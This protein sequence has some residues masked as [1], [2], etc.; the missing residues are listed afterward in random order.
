MLGHPAGRDVIGGG[1]VQDGATEA[2]AA[3]ERR[4]RGR[5]GRGFE[6]QRGL[7]QA[8]AP[9]AGVR[10]A[11]DLGGVVHQLAAGVQFGG[12]VDAHGRAEGLVAELVLA[13]P[14]RPDRPAGAAH[15]DDRRID[16]RVVR[17]VVAI[18][19]GALGVD[20]LDL[21]RGQAAD[22]G[23]HGAQ[24]I[25]ALSVGPDSERAVLHH[26]EP[27]GRAHG[28]VRDIG[29][30]VGGLQ[31]AA[32]GFAWRGLAGG[33]GGVRKI[34]LERLRFGE[35]WREIAR[36][37]PFGGLLCDVQRDCD[38]AFALGQEGDE[39][40]FPKDVDVL[41]RRPADRGLVDRLQPRLEPR[42]TQDTGVQHARLDQVVQEG[43]AEHLGRQVEPAWRGPDQPVAIGRLGRDLASRA[44]GQIH[45]AGQR[46][47]GQAGGR[48][49]VHEGAILDIEF[50]GVA[51]QA[52]SGG[53][54][55]QRPGLGASRADRG[56]GGFGAHRADGQALVW[57]KVGLQIDHVQP[58]Q[59][60]VQ[61][62]GG[63]L[64]Q[65]GHGAL[66]IFDLAEGDADDARRLEPHPAVKAWIGG[67]ARRD[68]RPT[69]A[70]MRSAARATA[71]MIRLCAPQRQRCQD[72]A[73][74][75]SARLGS[76]LASI[77]AL[78]PTSMPARQ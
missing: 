56:A 20:H 57:R 47:I 38:G 78:A 40:S 2:H 51:A 75:I 42:L 15:G 76:G 68:H 71:A 58:V 1:G 70:R 24:G 60:D 8:A 61:L 55:E 69:S 13:P 62:L 73:S 63:D 44:L 22:A 30:S 25:D 53:L 43:R 29:P 72:S 67:E 18:G 64:R 17:A 50:A 33:I 34:A 6:A 23:Q 3:G 5:R 31:P 4:W 11:P 26:R 10:A 28:A 74:A 39:V 59:A 41:A 77:S 21:V 35:A 14:L 49:A 16:R 54:G 46:P 36:A 7:G 9:A 19:P 27:A 65:A 32:V 52:P 48:A 66:T 37:I 12:Q 45:L